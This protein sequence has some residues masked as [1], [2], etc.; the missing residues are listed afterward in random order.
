MSYDWAGTMVNHF[1][2]KGWLYS[3]FLGVAIG[4]ALCLKAEIRDFSFTPTGG[5]D[6]KMREQNDLEHFRSVWEDE[7]RREFYVSLIAG[8]GF[9]SAEDP[10]V[11]SAIIE[12]CKPIPQEPVEEYLA[13]S[14]ECAEKEVPRLLRELERRGGPPFHP[15]GLVV[16]IG[17]PEAKDQPPV[18]NATTCLDGGLYRRSVRL[19][20]RVDGRSVTVLAD[21]HYGKGIGC[22][23]A[24]ATGDLQLNIQDATSLFDGPLDRL[25]TAL[26]VAN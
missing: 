6:M 15:V 17:V 25:E 16:K 1:K 22:G 11:V 23:T 18:G 4:V 20:N 3:L 5:I 19:V 24:F 10:R 12:T 8:K 13:L 9:Y 14:Q 26:A 2:R 21:R 7:D